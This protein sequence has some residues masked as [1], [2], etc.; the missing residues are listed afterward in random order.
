MYVTHIDC[1]EAAQGVPIR[2]RGCKR[3]AAVIVEFAFVAPL[4]FLFILAT[5]EFGRTFMVLEL[6]R[7][8]ARIGCRK[9]IIEGTT[10]Q[11]I[12]DSVTG[13][14]SS[15][16]INGDTV[17]V[18]V[19]DQP[20]NTVEA[21]TQPAYTEMT[22]QVTVPVATITWVPNPWFTSG[23]LSAQFTLRRE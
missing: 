7:E 6:L 11:Q 15:L 2:A 3:I 4:M 20:V 10:S 12:R 17:G 21:A 9:A 5:F 19:N 23:T 1:R 8:G 14:L 22:V 16:G 13:Y 18:S